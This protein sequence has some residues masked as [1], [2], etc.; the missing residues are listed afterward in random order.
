M[1]HDAS[2]LDEVIIMPERRVCNFTHEEIEPGTGMMFI[3]RDGTVFWF[4]DSKARKNRE[5]KAKSSPTEVDS[6]I[7]KGRNQV[8]TVLRVEFLPAYIK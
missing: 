8:N 6:P 4:K 3:K 2:T 7:R 5:A 1:R